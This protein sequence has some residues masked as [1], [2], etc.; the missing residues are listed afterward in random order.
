MKTVRSALW[1][2]LEELRGAISAEQISNLQDDLQ[3]LD[4]T[5][6]ITRLDI[7]REVGI[8]LA[9]THGKQ[10]RQKLIRELPPVHQGWA[11]YA[12]AAWTVRALALAEYLERADLALMPRKWAADAA[13]SLVADFEKDQT[14]LWPF[15]GEPPWAEDDED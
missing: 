4:K 15:D 1:N 11:L 8:E 5:Q 9:Q 3:K 12:A 7:M 6:L 13:L 2:L 10:K 14:W